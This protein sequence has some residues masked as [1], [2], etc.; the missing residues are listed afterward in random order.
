MRRALKS[1]VQVDMGRCDAGTYAL[2]VLDIV[3]G[4]RSV[5]HYYIRN[6]DDGGFYVTPKYTFTSLEELVKFHSGQLNS[7]YFSLHLTRYTMYC[8][9]KW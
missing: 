8:E 5:K 4:Q 6:L 3:N 2:S 7:N 9:V 1:Y